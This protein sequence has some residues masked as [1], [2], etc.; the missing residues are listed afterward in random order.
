MT[1]R[2]VAL[3]SGVST[4]TVSRVLNG[5]ASVSAATALKVR[6]EVERLG[7]TMNWAARSLKKGSTRTV[8]VIAP[9]LA[10]DFFMLLAE[11]MDRELSGA[12][13]SLIVCSSWESAD[14]EAKRMRLLAGRLVDGLV[15]IPATGSGEGISAAMADGRH[16][17]PLVLVDRLAPGVAADAVLVD[18]EGGAYAATAALAAEG[19]AQG[20]GRMGFIGGGLG[21]SI[22]RERYEG[23]R[24]AMSDSG[25]EVEPRFTSFSGLHVASGYESLR[26]M[27]SCPDAPD[28]YFLANAYIHV[29]ATNYLVSEESAARSAGVAFAAFDEMP[30]SPLLRFC[31]YSLSQPVAEMG[32][33]AARILLSRILGESSAPPE[34]ARLPVSLIRHDHIP[35]GEKKWQTF[36]A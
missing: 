17:S 10:S 5:D 26:A 9:E 30:W 32:A 28:A 34:T 35:Q 33:L 15:V 13:Y 4:A 31:R 12:G 6:D 36:P 22:A 25:L 24:R 20:R 27:R 8:G 7:Y 14:E 23:W 29:G 2:D 19:I 16:A 11:S 3:A 18:N 21:L 1:I